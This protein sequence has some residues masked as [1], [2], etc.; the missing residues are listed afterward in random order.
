MYHRSIIA[1]LKKRHV[2]GLENLLLLRNY[3]KLEGKLRGV[4]G[5][6]TKLLVEGETQLSEERRNNCNGQKMVSPPEMHCQATL[7]PFRSK[8]P[9]CLCLSIPE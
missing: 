8:V 3:F 5:P 7:V 9:S 4:I 1:F 6:S 2:F